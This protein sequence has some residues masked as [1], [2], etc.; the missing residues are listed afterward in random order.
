MSKLKNF[1]VS[2]IRQEISKVY[3]RFSHFRENR[4]RF[5]DHE[6]K[7]QVAELIDS[8][9][10]F[11]YFLARQ[12]DNRIPDT[13]FF[14]EDLILQLQKPGENRPGI[15]SDTTVFYLKQLLETTDDQLKNRS[16]MDSCLEKTKKHWEEDLR[17]FYEQLPGAG[18]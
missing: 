8:I 10:D 18:K 2:N 16:V 1:I 4:D 14:R 6:Y 17:K 11:L 12:I 3:R 9:F 7:E 5:E 13:A 15:L